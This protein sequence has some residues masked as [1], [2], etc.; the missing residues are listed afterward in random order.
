M[1]KYILCFLFAFFA[2]ALLAFGEDAGSRERRV[3]VALALFPSETAVVESAPEPKEKQWPTFAEGYSQAVAT[4]SVLIVYV[5]CEGSHPITTVPNC[6][7][8]T[9]KELPT[10]G[11]GTILI[12]YPFYNRLLEHK[13]LKCEEY[14][15]VAVEAAKAQKKLDKAA[16]DGDKP[17]A[18]P[19]DWNMVKADCCS[20]CTG[21]CKCADK[22]KCKSNQ[23]LV[24]KPEVKLCSKCK[25]CE[26][27][28][29]KEAAPKV[30]PKAT[31]TGVVTQPAQL[32]GYTLYQN[33]TDG[34]YFYMLNGTSPAC[35]N[36]R[37]PN[38]R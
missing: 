4:D 15:V 33:P 22:E 35:P 6:V 16:A 23:C 19:L 17:I 8:A 37:C 1:F 29:K 3:K 38:Q 25:D 32:Q 28:C 10:Y 13:T 14:L 9:Q 2:T 5:G 12:A 18:K 26:C 24:A 34:S 36:G 7:V 30:E 21:E 31:N 20:Y 27:E 11:K